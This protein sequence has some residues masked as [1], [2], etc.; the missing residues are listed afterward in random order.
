MR[1]LILTLLLAP[2]MAAAEIEGISLVFK[3]DALAPLK[4]AMPGLSVGSHIVAVYPDVNTNWGLQCFQF[5]GTKM[6]APQT[7]AAHSVAFAGEH[8]YVGNDAGIEVFDKDGRKIQ[9]LPQG[10]HRAHLAATPDGRTIFATQN[11]APSSLVVFARDETTGKLTQKQLFQTDDDGLRLA[12][13]VKRGGPISIDPAAIRVPLFVGAGKKCTDE[14][15]LF[16]ACNYSH[17]LAV[18]VRTGKGWEHIQSLAGSVGGKVT[19]GMMMC[20]SVA[21]SAQGDVFVGGVKSLSWLRLR[22]ERLELVKSWWDDSDAAAVKPDSVLPFLENVQ[23]LALSKNGKFLF[24]GSP[25]AA[26][27]VVCKLVD[28][29]LAFLGMLKDSPAGAKTLDVALSQ[30]G[31]KLFAKTTTCHLLIYDLDESF[32]E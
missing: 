10:M 21:A 30:D 1:L 24:L 26:G 18:F 7:S 27:I 25:D 2:S 6:P 12:K 8:L 13:V 20:Q 19:N 17:S 23:T 11:P 14:K 3:H 28:D 5:D 9:S 4:E 16:V 15:R 32:T 22:G 29:S 31:K